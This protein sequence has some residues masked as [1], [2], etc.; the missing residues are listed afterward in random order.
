MKSPSNF[1]RLVLGCIDSYDSNHT[2]ILQHFF[3]IYKIVILLQRSDT[4]FQQDIVDFL[5]GMKRIH[6]IEFAFFDGFYIF[7][8]KI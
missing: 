1:E 4:K 6:F 2:P 5:G 3:E 8:P 7:S